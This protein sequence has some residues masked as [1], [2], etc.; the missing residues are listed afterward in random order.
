MMIAVVP[1]ESPLLL[2]RSRTGGKPGVVASGVMGA[3]VGFV[4][5]DIT[6]C[7]SWEEV[8]ENREAYS[9]DMATK[10]M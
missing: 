2:R 7:P 3:T 5:V 10:F 1:D 4:L 6:C 8:K 9:L